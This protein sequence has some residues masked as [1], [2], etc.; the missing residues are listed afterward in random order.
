M[1]EKGFTLIE[2]IA[3]IIILGVIAV[4]TVPSVNRA[5]EKSKTKSLEEQIDRIISSA[6]NYA[7]D[8]SD[9]LPIVNNEQMLIKVSDLVET[10]FLEEI[11]KS[12][13]TEEDLNECIIVT[14]NETKSKYEYEYGACTIT[15][16]VENVYPA[17]PSVTKIY[18]ASSL[19]G[20]GS[21]RAG[22]FASDI[23]EQYLDLR[24]SGTEDA[25][26]L[27]YNQNKELV[28]F[29]EEVIYFTIPDST[30]YMYFYNYIKSLV[31]YQRSNGVPDTIMFA[32]PSNLTL[33]FTLVPSLLTEHP[34]E[35][36]TIAQIFNGK[37]IDTPE[38]MNDFFENNP[39]YIIDTVSVIEI[40]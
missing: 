4:I 35:F 23:D 33:G 29:Y 21:V 30:Y 9:K 31:D 2:L 36:A 18:L 17:Y 26:I 6:K 28:N 13:V 7:I 24:F 3:V 22:D 11:P 20:T 5:I 14:Y 10:G 34:A 19:S 16:G 38:K 37:D 12:P 15:S 32:D 39:D 1:K 8:N 27:L 40:D 25:I